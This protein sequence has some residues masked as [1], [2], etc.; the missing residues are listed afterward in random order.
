MQPWELWNKVAYTDYT[1]VGLQL[2]YSV[3]VIDGRACLFFQSSNQTEDWA[4]NFDFI[5]T[6]YKKQQNHML[7]HHGYASVWKS[8]N[9]QIMAEFIAAARTTDKQP[10]IA[11]WSFGGAMAILAAEDFNY[12]TSKKA[13]VVTFGAPKIA[14]D[15]KTVKYIKSCGNFLQYSQRC[16]LIAMM[17]PLPWFHHINK[18]NIGRKFNIFEIFKPQIYHADYWKQEI[19]GELNYDTSI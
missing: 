10:L 16:D 12:R 14:G 5:R 13:A 6:V 17:P 18:V 2:D 11:G 19:Y 3:E 1:T 4:H 9:D 7:I 8:A 15:R